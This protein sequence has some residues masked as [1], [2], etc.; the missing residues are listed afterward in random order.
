MYLDHYIYGFHLKK[1]EQEKI[2][3]DVAFRVEVIQLLIKGD[4]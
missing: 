1:K 4:I 3:L 2:M